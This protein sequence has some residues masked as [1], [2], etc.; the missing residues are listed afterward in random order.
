MTEPF[1]PSSLGERAARNLADITKTT[2]QMG[3][4][5]PRWLLRMLPWADVE[6][7][8]YRLNRVRVVGAE[9]E[10]VETRIDGEVAALQPN[11]L[12]AIP[13]FRDLD[14]AMAER[15][16]ARFRSEQIPAGTEIL[17]EGEP[18]REMYILSAGKAEV[19]RSVDGKRR[20]VL[21]V[22]QPG[23]YFGEV[24]LLRD[25]NRNASVRALTRVLAL[26]L[27]KADLQAL[28]DEL[29]GMRE[30]VEAS[31]GARTGREE[32]EVKLTTNTGG[33]E[34]RI[35]STFVDYEEF[36]DEIALSSITTTLRVHTRVMDLY[37]QPY[38]QLREQA[39]LV[40]E[41]MKERQE[42][43]LINN[44]DFGLLRNAAPSMR[45]PTR[46]GPPTPDDLDEL[47]S[48]VWKEPSFFLAHP[49][50]IAAFGRECTRRGVPPPTTTYYGSQ[51]ITWRGVPLIPSDKMPIDR[52]GIGPR[53]RIALMRVGEDRRGVTGLHQSNIGDERLPSFA[54]RFNGV[55]EFGVANYLVSV[56]FS[57]AVLSDDALGTLDDV[58]L[59]NYHSYE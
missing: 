54:L 40:I 19:Y 17:R 36:P 11:R 37:K 47:L 29:P 26:K 45:L 50:A 42:W 39:R 31:A 2:A 16:A 52:S 5:S 44:P 46:T 18:G 7:G 38:D 20:S 24:A 49:S 15:L 22:L 33:G 32:V 48:R 59:G 25:E 35:S 28:L 56:Y 27:D 55:D 13:L 4:L 1:E 6:A 8:L 34:P 12:R 58:E 53:T 14:D 41:S 51:F 21:T 43:E 23:D 3:S 9:F 10:R 57:L 30:M